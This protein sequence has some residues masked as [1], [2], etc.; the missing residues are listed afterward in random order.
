MNINDYCK[1][2]VLSIILVTNYFLKIVLNFP[3]FRN[4]NDTG[5]PDH[6]PVPK[7]KKYFSY[8]SQTRD[9]AG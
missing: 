9:R 4:G 7:Y 1:K 2:K 3:V 8:P 6:T 5:H